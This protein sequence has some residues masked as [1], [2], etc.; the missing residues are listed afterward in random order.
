MS[1]LTYEKCFVYMDDIIIFGRNLDTH[2]RNLTEVFEK[3]RK[4]NL[5]VNPNK[6]E[7]LKKQ[8][9]Y[10]GHVVTT[11]GVS[12]DPDKI[13]TVQNYP[14]PINSDEVRR[15]VAFCNYYRKFIPSFAEITIPLNKL[16]RKHATFNWNKESDNAFQKLKEELVSPPILQYPNF[17]DEN[18]FMKDIKPV[19][20]YYTSRPLNKAELY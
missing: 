19:A 14:K 16:C 7:F 12:P 1:G 18:E 5:K 11:E 17:S 13:K 20:Y 8:L 9:L 3:L 6:C 4:V 15:F 2:N 10:L